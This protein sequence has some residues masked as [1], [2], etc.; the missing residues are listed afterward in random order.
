MNAHQGRITKRGKIV[1]LHEAGYTPTQ[2]GRMVTTPEEDQVIVAEVERA[3]FTT[4][5]QIRETLGLACSAE[6]VRKRL[7]D[8]YIKHRVPAVKEK[9]IDQ[10]REQRLRFAQEYKLIGEQEPHFWQMVLFT[11]EKTFASKT[12]GK[13]YI[14]RRDGTRYDVEQINQLKK[15]GHSTFNVWG[16]IS[17]HGVGDLVRIVGRFNQTATSRF[18]ASSWLLW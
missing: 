2:I 17:A 11:D 5:V 4:A 10:Q 9:L 15:F 18:S 7:K 16:Y 3:P 6:T 14:W 8:A 1:A 13:L 12:H